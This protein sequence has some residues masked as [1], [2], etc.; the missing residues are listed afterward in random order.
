MSTSTRH[1][2]RIQ[3][4]HVLATVHTPNVVFLTMSCCM[5]TGEQHGQ[6]DGGH[7]G[8]HQPGRPRRWL[9]GQGHERRL[10]GGRA[11]PGGGTQHD[12]TP[13]THLTDGNKLD[14]V[15]AVRP[16]ITGL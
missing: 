7:V 11:Q 2:Q 8:A 4:H 15:S 9:S 6:A 13:V 5:K 14:Q 16:W 3:C 1:V 10:H 12:S